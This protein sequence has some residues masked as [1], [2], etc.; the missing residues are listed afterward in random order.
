M[1]SK[2]KNEETL[3]VSFQLSHKDRPSFHPHFRKIS[4]LDHIPNTLKFSMVI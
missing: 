1:Q 3:L 2:K 4:I